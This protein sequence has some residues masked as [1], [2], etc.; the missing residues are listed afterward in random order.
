MKNYGQHG[1]LLAGILAS[2][3]RL[4]VTPGVDAGA[5]GEDAA[6]AAADAA[7]AGAALR[8]LI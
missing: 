6:E 2:R 4:I 5:A 7:A 3:G 1:A 8:V